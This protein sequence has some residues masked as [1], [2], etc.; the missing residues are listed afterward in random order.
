[1]VD[2]VYEFNIVQWIVLFAFIGFM[3]LWLTGWDRLTDAENRIFRFEAMDAFMF[4]DFGFILMFLR[5]LLFAAFL[6]SLIFI[7]T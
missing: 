1:M 4:S 3:F 7:V 2:W 5:N 6:L